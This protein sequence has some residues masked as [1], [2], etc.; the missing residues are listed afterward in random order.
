MQILYLEPRY[1]GQYPHLIRHFARTTQVRQVF[2][3][4]AAHPIPAVT[5]GVQVRSYHAEEALPA[6]LGFGGELERAGRRAEAVRRAAQTLQAEG[7]RPD[8]VLAHGSFGEG[9]FIKDVFP[10]T[11]VIA[12]MEYYYGVSGLI[13]SD[14]D[15]YPANP[16]AE[17]RARL[18]NA[19]VWLT[20]EVADAAVTPMHWQHQLFPPDLRARIQVIHDGIDTTAIRPGPA[21][22]LQVPSGAVLHPGQPIVTFCARA[23]EPVRGLHLVL[24]SLP[25][26]LARHPAARI[27]LVGNPGHEYGAPAPGGDWVTHLLDHLPTTLDRSRL[28]R[29]PFLPHADLIR[30][31]QLS[32][33]HIYASLP[34]VLSWSILE[35]MAAGA[36][37]V[38]M[39]TP[40]VLEAIRDGETGL[41]F[42]IG[43]TA[44]LARQVV[45]LLDSPA[46]G[47]RLG[48]AGRAMVQQ[49]YDLAQVCLPLHDQLIR[50]LALSRPLNADPI[51]RPWR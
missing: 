14:P 11:R 50:G 45:S 43:D 2:L 37:V 1:P 29:A 3:Q 20:M 24:R 25:E 18:R 6:S 42:P 28:I 26:I 38:A 32:R 7:F 51:P 33:A 19:L 46:L 23:L 4:S 41:T 8:V 47:E 36:P 17:R 10:D 15:F 48:Q 22:P 39:A 13:G 9:L 16:D 5:P 34:F 12:F 21:A 44:A 31:F 49:R 35:A 40:P 27:V 30:L